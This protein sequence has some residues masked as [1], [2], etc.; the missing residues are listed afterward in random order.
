MTSR[1]LDVIVVGCS[2]GGLAAAGRLLEA[3]PPELDVPI[4]IVQH[5]GEAPSVLTKLLSRHTARPVVE[6]DD[7]EELRACHVYVAPSGYHLLLDRKGFS[8]ATEAP[9]R[10][11]R[12]SVDVLFESAADAFGH[13]TAAVVLTG[14]NDDGAAGLRRVAAVG[15]LALVQDPATAERS[16]MPTAA[17]EAVPTA[18]VADIAG[19]ARLLGRATAGA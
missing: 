10:H 2:W 12:P 6:P 4:V 1:D 18:L 13:R 9:V 17:L 3:L 15:G 11:S 8:L 19:L 16:M 5:R 14:S 7:K